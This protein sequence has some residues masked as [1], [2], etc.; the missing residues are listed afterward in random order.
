MLTFVS[1]DD[2]RGK[3]HQGISQ[4]TDKLSAAIMVD[5]ME[6]VLLASQGQR[7]RSQTD[8]VDKIRRV[9]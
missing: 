4:S 1:S 7:P 5:A 6:T 3:G 2:I 8:M 9:G